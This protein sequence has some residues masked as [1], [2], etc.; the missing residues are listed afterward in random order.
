MARPGSSFFFS[1]GPGLGFHG[2]PKVR[3]PWQGQAGRHD[4]PHKTSEINIL[5]FN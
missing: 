3:F 4:I 2:R 1:A 5:T